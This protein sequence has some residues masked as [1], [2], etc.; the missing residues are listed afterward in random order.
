M[1]RLYLVD[2]HALM[3]EGLRALLE[4]VGHSVVGEADSPTPALADIVRLQPDVVLL[5]LNL[6]KRSGFEV[7]QEIERRKLPSKVVVLTMSDQP[8][9]VAE[10]L[11]MGAMGYALKGAASAGLLQAIDAA[12]TGHR[13][14]GAGEAELAVRGLIESGDTPMAILSPRERQILLMIA[15]GASSAAIGEQLHLSS[16]TIDTYRSRLM[17]KLHLNDVSAVVR[18]AIRNGLISADEP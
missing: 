8:R 3:R 6:G 10:A 5:D 1:S 9:H 4:G 13:F 18:W 7:L 14:L 12:M 16:K 17:S 15:R 11:R 2:D